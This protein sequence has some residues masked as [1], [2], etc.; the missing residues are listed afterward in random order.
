[1]QKAG[2]NLKGLSLGWGNLEEK[3]HLMN[4]ATVYIEKKVSILGVK[5]LYKLNRALLGK[6]N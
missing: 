3:P 1:M 4:W 6:W 5:G 2:K